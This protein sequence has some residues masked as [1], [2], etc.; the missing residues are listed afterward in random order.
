MY[1]VEVYSEN[2]N[3]V[4]PTFWVGELASEY[5]TLMEAKRAAE[6]WAKKNM[7]KEEKWKVQYQIVGCL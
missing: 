7:R 3:R 1:Q 2:G 4:G 6:E 5:P